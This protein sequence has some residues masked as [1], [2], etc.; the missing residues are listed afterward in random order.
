MMN[1]I[2]IV[3]WAAIIWASYKLSVKILEKTD[4]L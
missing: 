2:L 4:N 3:G 1:A